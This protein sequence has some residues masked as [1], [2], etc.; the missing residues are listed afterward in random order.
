MLKAKT[1]AI[2]VF[3]PQLPH[4]IRSNLRLLQID[5]MREKMLV[6]SVEILAAE[7]QA[8][9]LMSGHTAAGPLRKPY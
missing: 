3:E 7:E 8:G 2:R 6:S 4:A 9:V 5:S 1:V